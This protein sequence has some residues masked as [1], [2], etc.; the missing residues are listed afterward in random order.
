MSTSDDIVIRP[1]TLDDIAAM[2]PLVDALAAQHVA[3]DVRRYAPPA[4]A[5]TVRVYGEWLR[6]GHAD[7]GTH[8]RQP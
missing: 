1:A 2:A 5:D 8:G 7:G 3:Y 4:P 6:K